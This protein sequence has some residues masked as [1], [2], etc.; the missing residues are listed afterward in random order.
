[1]MS[2]AVQVNRNMPAAKIKGRLF[3]A[4]RRDSPK[5]GYCRVAYSSLSRV[6]KKVTSNGNAQ[7]MAKTHPI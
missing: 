6:P 5:A 4:A 3:H 2:M 1:M 7:A